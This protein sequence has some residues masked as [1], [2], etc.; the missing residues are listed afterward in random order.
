M[1]Y[2]EYR[3]EAVTAS[4]EGTLEGLVTPFN[5]ETVIGD[6]DHGGFREE[7]ASGAFTKTLSEGDPLMVYQHDLTRPLARVSAG[8]LA[9][10]ESG[11]GLTVKAS[12]VDTSYAR[13]LRELIRS[14]VIQGMSFGFH[15]KGGTRA[16]N[17]RVRVRG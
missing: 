13:D 7:V 6:L 9:L 17:K 15:P 2:R 3:A 11:E 1:E 12:P 16:F 4:D 14:G 10:R 8:N 5:R